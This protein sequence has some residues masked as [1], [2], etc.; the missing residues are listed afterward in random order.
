MQILF[1]PVIFMQKEHKG[2]S[3]LL[4]GD[5]ANVDHQGKNP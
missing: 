5:D 2:S 4:S 3:Q 1:S